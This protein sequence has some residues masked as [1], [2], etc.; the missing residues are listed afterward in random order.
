[1]S[2]PPQDVVLA[3]YDPLWPALFEEERA[4][5]LGVVPPPVE[6]H[7][8]GSTSIPGIIARPLI[9]M[10]LAVDQLCPADQYLQ[11]LRPLGYELEDV[12]ASDRWLVWKGIP[13]THHIHIVEKNSWHYWRFLLFRDWL[14]EHPDTAHRYELLKKELAAKLGYDRRAYSAAKGEFIC[15]VVRQALAQHPHLEERFALV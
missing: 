4:A 12:F 5:V 14:R 2:I 13:K 8:M 9:D 15:E 10:L 3:T 6:L 7:H 1:M 11:W